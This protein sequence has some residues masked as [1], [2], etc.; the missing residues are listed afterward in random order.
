MVS[1]LT[2]EDVKL[3]M[4]PWEQGTVIYY[5]LLE[6][7]SCK[8]L[9]SV[10]VIVDLVG[11]SKK[12]RVYEVNSL[13]RKDFDC[14]IC[15]QSVIYEFLS[16]ETLQ[17]SL[18][19]T[20]R[21]LRSV[22][23][24]QNED[25]FQH[26]EEDNTSNANVRGKKDPFSSFNRKSGLS[27]RTFS[28]ESSSSYED[29]LEELGLLRKRSRSN[30]NQKPRKQTRV[31]RLRR[32]LKEVDSD[33]SSDSSRSSEH[34]T[35]SGRSLSPESVK[36]ARRSK[37]SHQRGRSFNIDDPRSWGKYT[38]KKMNSAAIEELYAD[39]R[40]NFK[41]SSS[42]DK[43]PDINIDEFIHKLVNWAK[44][45]HNISKKTEFED[46]LRT[47]NLL[48]QDLVNAILDKT[49]KKRDSV[50]IGGSSRLMKQIE[51]VKPE[52][53]KSCFLCHQQGHWARYCPQKGILNKKIQ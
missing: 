38:T 51:G 50:I 5:K 52:F 47:G 18:E 49:G 30:N 39:L 11:S 19:Y 20:F 7:E 16:L 21:F 4:E 10:G 15:A 41:V 37:R 43:R 25:P 24:T 40:R 31:K 12:G 3:K 27:H 42:E 23:D 17:G 46:Y 14:R 9:Q 26:I 53:K 48:M 36:L 6:K 22:N 34:S 28:E 2:L 29:P 44:F 45:A 8:I 13:F 33:T 32:D 1:L 35:S